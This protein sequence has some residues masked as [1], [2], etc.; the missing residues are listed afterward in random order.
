M[1]ET[2]PIPT[3]PST[4]PTGAAPSGRLVGIEPMIPTHRNV[5]AAGKVRPVVRLHSGIPSRCGVPPDSLGAA[6]G[7]VT[8]DREGR[9]PWIR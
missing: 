2:R 7:Q 5:G 4:P 6:R 8:A 9:S 1:S 3:Y